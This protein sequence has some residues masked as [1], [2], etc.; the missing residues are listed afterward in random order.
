[1]QH[2]LWII[3]KDGGLIYTMG[4][5]IETPYTTKLARPIHARTALALLKADALQA[6]GQLFPGDKPTSYVV[7]NPVD[8]TPV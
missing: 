7:R 8:Q 4:A 3:Q 1:M 5:N 2:A 6:E